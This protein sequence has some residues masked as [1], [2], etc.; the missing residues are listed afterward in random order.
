MRNL[1]LALFALVAAL[2]ACNED[3]LSPNHGDM[4]IAPDLLPGRDLAMRVNDGV[5]CGSGTNVTT[6]T[7]SQVCCI[8]QSG[9]GA[10]FMC[11]NPGTCGDGG[12]EAMCDGP[13]DC[14]S[15]SPNCCVTV[16]ATLS[17]M[18]GGTPT[19]TGANAM[20]TADCPA[21]AELGTGDIT[22]HSKL[23]HTTDDCAGYMGTTP[24]GSGDFDGCCSSAMAPG[25]H[26]CAPSRFAGARTYQCL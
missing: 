25:I 9:T 24:L 2:P 18:D 4:S 17:M 15:A 14:P 11:V 1:R 5:Q 20:C 6:C 7:G 8:K 12:A 26:F 13:E 3:N 21:T 16:T 19:P 22:L 10:T 23:C